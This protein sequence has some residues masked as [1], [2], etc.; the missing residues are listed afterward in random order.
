MYILYAYSTY[1][2]FIMVIYVF[3]YILYNRQ[4]IC[5]HYI[6]TQ[7]P[8]DINTH[9]HTFCLFGLTVIN[10][11]VFAT[12]LHYAISLK[13]YWSSYSSSL[14]WMSQNRDLCYTLKVWL[15]VCWTMSKKICYHQSSRNATLL[16]I[17]SSISNNLFCP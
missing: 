7:T 12:K 2:H 8:Y 16:Y 14:K 1:T 6:Y 11:F 13:T 17:I 4:C 10:R 5:R 9:T 15:T 3:N